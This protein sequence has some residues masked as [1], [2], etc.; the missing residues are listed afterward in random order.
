MQA[1]SPPGLAPSRVQGWDLPGLRDGIFKGS[2]WEAARVQGWDL[3]PLLQA[4]ELKAFDV[5]GKS[6][7]FVEL[8]TTN[9]H[10]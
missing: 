4:K 6:D 2:G 5:N 8:Y 9:E 1:P 10:T 7:P 3:P